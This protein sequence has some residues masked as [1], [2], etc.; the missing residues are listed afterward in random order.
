MNPPEYPKAI[1]TLLPVQAAEV[2]RVAAY[3]DRES[4]ANSSDECTF[5]VHA[6]R[7]LESLGCLEPGGAPKR[8]RWNASGDNV[9]SPSL[10]RMLGERVEA[11]VEITLEGSPV[12]LVTAFEQRRGDA[13]RFIF[14]GRG[15]TP[16]S[17]LAGC[18]FEA[19]ETF[20]A[21]WST[22][23]ETLEGHECVEATSV[24]T[25]GQVR[26]PL[27]RVFL[28][29]PAALRPADS[30]ACGSNGL[31]AGRD[32]EEA[33]TAALLELIERDAVAL[34]WRSRYRA[35]SYIGQS[36]A[37]HAAI[38]SIAACLLSKGR[39]LQL[40]DL[41]HDIGVPVVLARSTDEQGRRPLIGA[42]AD[43][44]ADD[45]AYGAASELLQ[46]EANIALVAQNVARQGTGG[47]PAK[48]R[49]LWDWHCRANLETHPFLVP[50]D[51]GRRHGCRRIASSSAGIGDLL[52]G[53]GVDAALVRLAD[54]GS[55]YPVVRA[56]SDALMDLQ[57]TNGRAEAVPQKLGLLDPKAARQPLNDA[58]IPL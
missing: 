46:M 13:E 24:T 57:T 38:A 39:R 16:Q 12:K 49:Q 20:S 22:V 1:M 27:H 8:L 53:A 43:P 35:P 51:A 19:I 7:W 3:C 2:G 47:L 4:K 54:P 29:L 30:P 56:V 26:L 40:L 32:H 42:A 31:A 14:S 23:A 9:R 11:L 58:V 33:A 6:V 34:W 17:A 5:N 50:D 37:G 15:P 10:L 25:G 48:T 55:G 41:T 28:E 45:A 36:R 44:F 52:A 18:L 21:L